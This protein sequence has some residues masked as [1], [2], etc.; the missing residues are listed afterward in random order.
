M[1][2][3]PP[4]PSLTSI[5]KLRQ[6]LDLTLVLISNQLSVIRKLADRVYLLYR[7]G[8]REIGSGKELEFKAGQEWEKMINF[9]PS[10]KAG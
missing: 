7:G 4:R 5:L 1:T 6:Q 9:D 3:S 8:V 2:P 10:H